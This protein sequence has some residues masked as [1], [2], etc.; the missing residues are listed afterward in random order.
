M[1]RRSVL[2]CRLKGTLM[3][4]KV[5]YALRCPGVEAFL[6]FQ[7]G[8]LQQWRLILRCCPGVRSHPMNLVFFFFVKLIHA[9]TDVT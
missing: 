9:A 3:S 4:A 7:V 6:Y 2:D 1:I 8:V 5:V